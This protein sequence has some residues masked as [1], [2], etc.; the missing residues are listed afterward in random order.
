MARGILNGRVGGGVITTGLKSPDK[1]PA[2]QTLLKYIHKIKVLET[3]HLSERKTG[4]DTV[5]I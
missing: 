5:V 1:T 3:I 2:A 4:V